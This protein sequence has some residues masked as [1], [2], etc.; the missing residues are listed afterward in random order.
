MFWMYNAPKA[1]RKYASG[2]VCIPNMAL[3]HFG[4]SILIQIIHAPGACSWSSWAAALQASAPGAISGQ[5]LT[6]L[7][8][9]GMATTLD[10]NVLRPV[11]VLLENQQCIPFKPL[12][13]VKDK[14][15]MVQLGQQFYLITLVLR[16]QIIE[17]K[18]KVVVYL[19]PID[20][21]LPSWDPFLY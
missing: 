17:H 5:N 12:H 14:P 4:L 16:M 13:R 6:E 21:Q 10:I 20:D 15:C 11:R 9:F 18:R 3:E 19:F 2:A 7:W 8:C 1:C